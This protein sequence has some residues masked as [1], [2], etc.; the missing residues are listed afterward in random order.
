MSFSL[1]CKEKMDPIYPKGSMWPRPQWHAWMNLKDPLDTQE[2]Q[3]WDIP[4][5]T[6]ESEW[7]CESLSLTSAGEE[8]CAQKLSDI[9]SKDTL[10]LLEESPSL[11][12]SPRC[13]TPLSI[14]KPDEA[15]KM[16]QLTIAERKVR[17]PFS[18]LS[19]EGLRSKDEEQTSMVCEQASRLA[20]DFEQLSTAESPT[21]AFDTPRKFSPISSLA[22]QEHPEF[23]GIGDPPVLVRQDASYR[24]STAMD[25]EMPGGPQV[26][27]S[28]SMG[29]TPT[30]WQS[31]MISG[32]DGESFLPFL[33]FWTDTP[34][35]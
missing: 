32:Q 23:F 26:G 6:S 13:E 31:S 24:T 28:G 21:K 22:D 30:K 10:S 19:W 8:K 35:E 33:D 34:C 2:R 9:I 1:Q 25:L 14:L 29:T 27:S 11:V 18:L 12:R 4:E 5:D 20:K 3:S 16:R 7:S 15:P 17:R